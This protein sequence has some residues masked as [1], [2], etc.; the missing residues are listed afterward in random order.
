MS[1]QML[2]YSYKMLKRVRAA[3]ESMPT[4]VKA[5]GGEEMGCVVADMAS[6]IDAQAHAIDRLE[7]KLEAL[8]DGK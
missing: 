8:E 2:G 4:M 5:M 1:E 7:E 6:L 3:V